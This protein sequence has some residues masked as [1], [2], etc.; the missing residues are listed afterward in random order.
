MRDDQPRFRSKYGAE[1]VEITEQ[2]RLNG[3]DVDAY[4]DRAWLYAKYGKYAQAIED[5]STVLKLLPNVPE[6][7]MSSTNVLQMCPAH[8]VKMPY[9]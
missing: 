5:L 6:K 3:N 8:P 7:K 1:R 4:E 2:I 9:I